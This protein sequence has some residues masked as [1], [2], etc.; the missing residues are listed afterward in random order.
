MSGSPR[1][2]S[3]AL[4]IV[5][6]LRNWQNDHIIVGYA[7]LSA[8]LHCGEDVHTFGL[9]LYSPLPFWPGFA[10]N[11]ANDGARGSIVDPTPLVVR[12]CGPHKHAPFQSRVH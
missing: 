1:K 9:E 6:I 8:L 4:A 7:K 5:H 12:E 10:E 11:E 2:V 3:V